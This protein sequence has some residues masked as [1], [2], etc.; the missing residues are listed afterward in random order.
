MEDR[1]VQ[2]ADWPINLEGLSKVRR[3]PKKPKMKL[4][5]WPGREERK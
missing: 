5:R 4:K 2:T 3:S 1:K